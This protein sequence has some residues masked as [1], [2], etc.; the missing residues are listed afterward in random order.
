MRAGPPLLEAPIVATPPLVQL[1]SLFLT[2]APKLSV[3]L[4]PFPTKRISVD[5]L[6][7]DLKNH[8]IKNF[9][10]ATAK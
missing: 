5:Y 1:G 10:W 9:L 8:Q 4:T 6:E 2:Y 3:P 7:W